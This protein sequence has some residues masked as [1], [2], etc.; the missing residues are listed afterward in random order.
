MT[1]YFAVVTDFMAFLVIVEIVS[2]V[3]ICLFA[4]GDI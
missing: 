2:F 1:G 3:G 4:L